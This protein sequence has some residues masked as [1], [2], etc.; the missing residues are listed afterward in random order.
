MGKKWDIPFIICTAAAFT[1]L[2]V[3]L[4]FFT[5][6]TAS[7]IITLACI[8][9]LSIGFSRYV[10]YRSTLL[11]AA[12]TVFTILLGTGVILNAWFFTTYLG[13]SPEYPV[14]INIDSHRWWNAAV[15]ILDPN[16]GTEIPQ[17]F[18]YYAH[19]LAAVLFVLGKSVGSALIFSMVLILASLFVTG[20]V[21]DRLT[22]NRSITAISVICLGL[23][24]Y[25]LSMGTLILK[26]AFIILAFAIGTLG[27]VSK[28]RGFIIAIIMAAVMLFVTRR[29]Y[30]WLLIFEVLIVYSNKKNLLVS[31]IAIGLCISLWAFHGEN[32]LDYFYNYSTDGD[33]YGFTSTQHLAYYNAIGSYIELPFFKKL[34]LYPVLAGVQ[35]L[36]PF[37]WTFARDIPF[38]LTQAWAHFGYPWYLFGFVFCYFLISKRKMFRTPLYRLSIAA[39]VCWLVPCYATGGTVSRYALP[40]VALMAPAV[41]YTLYRNVRNRRFYILTGCYAVV[42][43]IILIVAHH[44]QTAAMS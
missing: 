26:D 21:T 35:F 14:L 13:G 3:L 36:I 31:L 8:T 7:N 40:F 37:S 39:L 22:Q 17:F 34:L 9:I 28:E 10:S 32:L 29:Q 16:E 20:Y 25:W 18:G 30:L 19:I 2:G 15:N 11:T 12:I 33:N 4:M 38:G 6:L 5:G 23:V 41:A 24:C 1:V 44:L 42:L 43:A 27:M